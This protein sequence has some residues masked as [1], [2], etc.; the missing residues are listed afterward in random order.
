VQQLSE[1][2]TRDEAARAIEEAAALL[3]AKQGSPAPESLIPHTN[4]VFA[5]ENRDFACTIVQKFSYQTG[6]HLSAAE[7]ISSLESKVVGPEVLEDVMLHLLGWT[8][9]TTDQLI[10]DRK[11]A[12]IE[13]GTFRN[14]LLAIVR[15]LDRRQI[16]ASFA[17]MPGAQDVQ[18]HL[19]KRRYVE[20]IELIQ[21]THD[22][23]I[24]AI[25][26]Y[27]RA[28]TDRIEWARR[29]LVHGSALDETEEELTRA[30][31]NIK[32]ISDI[33]DA[34]R[35]DVERGKLLYAKCSL[36]KCRVQGQ[37][38]PGHFTPGS[39]HALA[40]VLTVGWHPR[41]R[42]LIEEENKE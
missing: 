10:A 14:E 8:K 42:E 31:E 12:W 38:P 16:L 18:S 37:E 25:A 7:I 6:T 29:G 21:A 34:S 41:Y 4:R 2:Q 17:R 26:D 3:Q 15:K 23:K 28:E 22:Q 35:D 11:A 40:D 36:H 9:N 30:W 33:E 5:P 39:F 1:A 27:L 20:Q 32:T 24:K 19:K 13:V